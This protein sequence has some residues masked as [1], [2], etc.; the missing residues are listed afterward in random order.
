MSVWAGY[1][2]AAAAPATTAKLF[3]KQSAELSSTDVEHENRRKMAP[4]FGRR[5][6]KISRRFDPVTVDKWPAAHHQ[7]DRAGDG[8]GATFRLSTYQRASSTKFNSSASTTTCTELWDV[9]FTVTKLRCR[10]NLG[11]K[12]PARNIK[13]YQFNFLKLVKLFFLGWAI[14]SPVQCSAGFFYSSQ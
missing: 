3:C 6:Q 11:G 12:F 8:L 1:P 13:N 14:C 9:E 10:E 5:A 7:N 2:G 4:T